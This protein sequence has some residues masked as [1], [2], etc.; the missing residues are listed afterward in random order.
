MNPSNMKTLSSR[1][2][3]LMLG[4]IVALA[5][6]AAA[7]HFG[8]EEQNPESTGLPGSKRTGMRINPNTLLKRISLELKVKN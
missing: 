4:V 6:G 8:G 7:Y 3:L 2:W 1:I 5:I